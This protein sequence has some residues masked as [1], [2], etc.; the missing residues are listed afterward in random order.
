MYYLRTKP[1]SNALQFTV[2]KLKLKVN[3]LT[4]AEDTTINGNTSPTSKPFKRVLRTVEEEDAMMVCSREN[5]DA[6]MMCSG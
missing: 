5:G 6:C 4:V 2:D 1:A 3:N